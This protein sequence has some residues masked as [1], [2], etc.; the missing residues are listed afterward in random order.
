MANS[1]IRNAIND[2]S[3]EKLPDVPIGTIL[4]WVMM[5]D[6][7]GGEVANLPKNWQKCD[8]SI[9]DHGIWEGKR[10]PDL[11]GEKRF[12][13]GGDDN[14]VLTLEEDQILDHIHDVFDEG[15][16]HFT[17]AGKE[18]EGHSYDGN[19][20]GGNIHN[21]NLQSSTDVSGIT[22]G[23]ITDSFRKGSENRPKNM[24]VVFVIRV[25]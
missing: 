2:I 5:V 3:V 7:N 25:S 21:V 17:Y 10:T 15:H 14:D 16:S 11:N 23:Y 13:R 24:N 1:D 6:K 8:G 18:G 20:W 22:V 19:G 12:L 4:S 9:I